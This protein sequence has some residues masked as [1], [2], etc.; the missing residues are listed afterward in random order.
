VTALE[1]AEEW[2]DTPTARSDI[3]LLVD[4]LAPPLL[5]FAPLYRP[6][7]FAELSA[8]TAD[9]PVTLLS[10]PAGSGKTV[11]AGSWMHAQPDARTMAWLTVES[12]DDDPLTF[13]TYLAAALCRAGLTVEPPRPARGERWPRTF[14]VG[15]AAAVLA[16]RRP[17]VLIL[18]NA[19]RLTRGPVID[20]LD[21]LVRHAGA[22]LRLVLCARAAPHLPLHRYRVTDRLTEIHA[23]RL[24]FTAAETRDLLTNFGFPLTPEAAAAVHAAT[25]G[26]SVALWWAADLLRRGVPPE[27]LPMSLTAADG[28][29]SAYVRAELLRSLTPHVRRFLLRISVTDELEPE[30]VHRLTG[31][32]DARRTLASLAATNAFVE[33]RPTAAGGYRIHP[34][35][36]RTL[37]AQ[38]ADEDPD[39]FSAG[40]QA[41]AAWFARAGRRTQA[42]RHAIAAGDGA[43]AAGFL[44]DDGAVARL[45]A[46][47]ADPKG[48]PL[49]AYLARA[50]GP[51]AAVLRAAAAL[52]GEEVP[53][54]AD[55]SV[56][57]S[58]ARRPDTSAPLRAAAAVVCAAT[59]ATDPEDQ[60]RAADSALDL[61]TALSDER[62]A[63]R[64]ELAAVLSVARAAALLRTDADDE[65]L[66]DAQRV[67]L[68]ASIAADAQRQGAVCLAA[69][70]LLAAL[71]GRLRRSEELLA[72]YRILCA[73]HQLPIA[74]HTATAATAAAWISWERQDVRDGQRWLALAE[75]AGPD[76]AVIRPLL[77]VLRSRLH[78]ARGEKLG[79]AEQAVQAVLD[80]PDPPRW[81]LESVLDE[82]VRLRFARRDGAAGLQLLDRIPAT[83]SH[84]A[85]LRATAGMLG[86]SDAQAALPAAGPE[87]LPVV[88]VETAVLRTCLQIR[89]GD[90]PGAIAEL[91]RA[92][93]LA[94]PE[95]LRRPF[96]D[97]S[98]S[99]W[100][101]LR[102]HPES[103]AAAAAWLRPTTPSVPAP[104]RRTP[105][106]DVPPE[107]A[108]VPS[109]DRLSN[110]ELEVLRHLG[111]AMST[112]EVA[113]VMF[114]S[115]NT[116]RTH[117]RG[118]L[119]KLAV[120][121]RAEAIR[122]ARARK[123]L[124]PVTT[125][126]RDAEDRGV[127]QPPRRPQ[128]E[129]MPA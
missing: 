75:R 56:S 8:G 104:R 6:R 52:A 45:L 98:E 94:E 18:D 128:P 26:W 93:R 64:D 127:L 119:A 10:G 39:R 49:P 109:S 123:L 13:A 116:V 32:P 22:R 78:R 129:R 42:V 14:A 28:G 37:A 61:V 73:A 17:V 34:L 62:R 1:Q 7:L 11:L 89:A 80:A 27:D 70:A 112:R 99:L 5:G 114:V 55:L 102:A 97:V 2:P 92:L 100:P 125:A 63:E 122:E 118:I 79:A 30:M 19:D 72:R 48:P 60:V 88:A 58:A 57:A 21:L 121:N 35:V 87:L 51:A 47:G 23:D 108:G 33:R 44:V 113:E 111:T 54:P 76:A 117:I 103:T 66:L 20:L 46:H 81:V 29:V 24:A 106:P 126:G 69:L 96:F 16:S 53:D 115:V 91:E 36:R 59:T 41:C 120:T 3:P 38:L 12:T 40:H 110:R 25:G 84:A 68:T 124:P 9:T 83:S 67:A 43:M 85:V 31:Q 90:S 4:Q 15:L 71:Q 74:Q 107:R 65:T 50:P 105:A 86:L 82:A 95:R 77:A 101:L